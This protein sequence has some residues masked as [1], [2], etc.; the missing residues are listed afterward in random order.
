MYSVSEKVWFTINGPSEM[1]FFNFCVFP[2]S[3][4][5]MAIVKNL[6]IDFKGS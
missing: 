4:F 6:I 1:L 2:L 3:R 5:Q